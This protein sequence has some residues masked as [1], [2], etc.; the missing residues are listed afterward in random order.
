VIL[1]LT[2]PVWLSWSGHLLIHADPL[3]KADAILVL[4]GDWKGERV[5]EACR[6]MG[7]GISP[8]AL[9]SGAMELYGQNE[10]D[11]AIAYATRQG[12]PAGSL[13]PAYLKASSTVEEAEAFRPV[14]E[15]RQV[16]RLLI[17]TSNYHTARARRIFRHILPSSVEVRTWAVRDALFDP[18]SWW[19]SREGQKSA[20]YEWSKTFAWMVGL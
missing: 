13:Q 16:H 19:R 12:C 14:V 1:F 10:A 8:V 3:E 6:L 20:F 7:Q 9:V 17:V 18:D 2:A 11:L 5:V 15:K 4:G